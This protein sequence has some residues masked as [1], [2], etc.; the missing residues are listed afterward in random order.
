V[1]PEKIRTRRREAAERYKP[2]SVDVLLVAEA[3]PGAPD[4]YFYFE[5]VQAQDSLFRYV[6]RSILDE[7]PTRENKRELLAKLRDRGVFLIDLK[8]DPLDGSPLAARVGSLLAR[9]RALDP[10]AIILIKA[11][12]YD[13]A[14]GFMKRAGLPAIDERIPFPGSGQ[15]RNFEEAFAKALESARRLT[16]EAGGV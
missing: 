7:E 1:D 11:T 15:Q 5:D 12:V 14:F 16:R 8:E 3:P 13:E 9:C 10:R 6:A 2:D 4:R